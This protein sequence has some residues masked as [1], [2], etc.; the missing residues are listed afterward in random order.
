MTV[1]AKVLIPFNDKYTGKAYKK[2]GTVKMTAAR[3]NEITRQGRFIELVETE[4]ETPTTTE[5]E[6]G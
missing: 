6:N 2:G 1:K 4:P 5:K 3:F